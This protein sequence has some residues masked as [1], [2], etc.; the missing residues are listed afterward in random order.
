MW[1]AGHY[2]GNATTKSHGGIE[3]VVTSSC[4][5]IINWTEDAA[6]VACQRFPDFSKVSGSVLPAVRALLVLG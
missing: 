4:G 6:Y 5:G 3:V 1:L 2:H